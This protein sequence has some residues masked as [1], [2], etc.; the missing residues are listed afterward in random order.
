MPAVYASLF[1]DRLRLAMQR[2]K[3]NQRRL[4]SVM[5]EPESAIS[6]WTTGRRLPS[7]SNLR[8]LCI[9]L[10][11]DANWL[12]CTG[13]LYGEDRTGEVLIE[14]DRDGLRAEVERLKVLCA[15]RPSV[16]E[17]QSLGELFNK[18]LDDVDAAGRGEG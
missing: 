12:L 18:W 8:Q 11:C 5:R 17:R 3:W 16:P 4:A 1:C 7:F 14:D 9:V 10:E 15:N 6:H 2:K 13:T